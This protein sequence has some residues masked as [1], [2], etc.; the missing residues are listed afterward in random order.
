M[1]LFTPETPIGAVLCQQSATKTHNVQTDQ[2]VWWAISLHLQATSI[3]FQENKQKPKRR[4]FNTS[5]V[6]HRRQKR[7]SAK[8]SLIKTRTSATACT[9]SQFPISLSTL[10]TSRTKAD[11][12]VNSA[13]LT[14]PVCQQQSSQPT[15]L[16]LST[17]YTMAH[18]FA[19]K[20]IESAAASRLK[21]QALQTKSNS[22]FS[23]HR[24]T[25]LHCQQKS[26]T[27]ND[28]SAS[29]KLLR[30]TQTQL[31]R[32]LTIHP[33]ST[34]TRNPGHPVRI[35]RPPLIV[36]SKVLSTTISRHASH[37]YENL[38]IRRIYYPTAHAA[39]TLNEN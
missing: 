1:F 5:T 30:R 11:M 13:V 3:T 37:F 35:F 17:T 33:A 20:L 14:F 23:P 18:T 29:L 22:A 24:L 34:T 16:I 7:I 19:I 4:L 2:N 9:G 28:L 31:I 21:F 32:S 39:T 25:S 6:P 36:S 27:D 26:S 15:D 10:Q 8:Y 12:L 38:H